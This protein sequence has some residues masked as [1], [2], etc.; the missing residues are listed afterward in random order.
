MTTISVSEQYKH[1]YPF[2][3]LFCF[4]N[5]MCILCSLDLPPHMSHISRAQMPG[6][7]RNHQK[8]RGLEQDTLWSS[9]LQKI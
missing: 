5:M 6:V 1:Y 7:A 9:M 3:I 2:N 8:A 4:P